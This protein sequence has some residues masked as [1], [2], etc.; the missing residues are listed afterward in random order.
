MSTLEKLKDFSKMVEIH[1]KKHKISYI[2][3]ILELCETN[4]LEPEAI[5]KSLSKP[6]KE[7]IELEATSKNLLKRKNKKLTCGD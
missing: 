1:V 2:D 5:S 3:A 6:I 7:K 4:N